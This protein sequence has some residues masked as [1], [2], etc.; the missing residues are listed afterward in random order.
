MKRFFSGFVSVVAGNYSAILLSFG[1]NVVL[2]RALGAPE[3]GHFALLIM[4]SQLLAFVVSNWTLAALVHFGARE[5]TAS[6]TVAEAY[7]TRTCLVLPWLAAAF[8]TAW[9][10]NGWLARYLDVPGWGVWLVFAHFLLTSTFN[11]ACAVLQAIG[12]MER[13]GAALFFDRALT[14]ALIV[15]G[16]QARLLDALSALAC[17]VT[18]ALIVSVWVFRSVGRSA[19]T[20]SRVTGGGCSAMWKFSLPL[21]GSTWAGL[22]GTQWI[23]YV[24]IKSYLP[25]SELGLYSLGYQVAGVVQQ[26]TII[27]STLLLPQFSIMVGE[28][29]EAELRRIVSRV[30]PYWLLG[31]SALLGV[32]LASARIVV[33]MI[34]GDAFTGSV[35]PLALLIVA[36]MAVAILNSFTPLLTAKGATWTISGVCLLSASVNVAMNLALIPRF[37]IV[38]AAWATAIACAVH[39]GLILAV[40]QA[41]LG[42]PLGR[43]PLLAAPVLAVYLCSN[44]VEGAVFYVAA[45][46]AVGATAF[47]VVRVF[48]LFV[49]SDLVLFSDVDLPSWVRSGLIKM[50]SLR[51]GFA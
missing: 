26:V 21:I 25:L 24:L 28:G 10:L 18:S 40:V 7:W 13:Y 15:V 49:H 43:Y 39:A 27:T 6:G 36:T 3:F 4:A 9:M 8:V 14:L 20:P 38:G 35:P 17:Y 22:F 51:G 45:A 33:P 12:H 30:I 16:R 29:R 19:M 44:L 31:F 41:H 1:I 46:A 48:R 37:G 11:T 42:V 5:F 50:F 32:V 2:T 47:G 23:D 34:F